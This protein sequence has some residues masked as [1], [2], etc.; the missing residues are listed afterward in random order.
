M[1]TLLWPLALLLS[2][3]MAPAFGNLPPIAE[4]A[5]TTEIVSR[6]NPYYDGRLRRI[7]VLSDELATRVSED[8]DNYIQF[9]DYSVEVTYDDTLTIRQ[10]EWVPIGSSQTALTVRWYRID[11]HTIPPAMPEAW[12]T[13]Y[14]G[15]WIADPRS[16]D[17]KLEDLE[18]KLLMLLNIVHASE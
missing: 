14:S 8:H 15:Q 5:A 10:L 12:Q 11:V 6:I 17:Q 9:L 1:R 18:K 3:Y 16:N 4:L 13:E 2:T 7:F